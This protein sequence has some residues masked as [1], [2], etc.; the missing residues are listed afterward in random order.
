[1]QLR[2]ALAEAGVRTEIYYPI[3]L[4]LQECFSYLGNARGSYPQSESAANETLA[5]PVHPNV[6]DEQLA[7]SS[8]CIHTFILSHRPMRRCNRKL[9][10]ETYPLSPH[11]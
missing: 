8:I 2:S 7:M 6:T 9:D 3:P 1:M 4:H 10:S 5:L 11:R